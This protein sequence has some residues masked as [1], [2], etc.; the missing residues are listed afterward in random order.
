MQNGVQVIPVPGMAGVVDEQTDH[1]LLEDLR[2]G[3]RDAATSLYERYA[4]RLRQLIRSKCSAAL[5]RRLDAD[6]I[7]QS[8]FHAFF[9]GA[10]GG[11]YQVPA[12][13]EIWPLL[14]VIALNKI[15]TQGS[16]HRAAKRDVR[17]TCGLDESKSLK[18]AV[19]DLEAPESV[20]FMQMVAD[21]ALERI[22]QNQREIIE[23]RMAGYEV[24]EIAQLVGRS[25][26]TVERILQSCRQ[27][28]SQILCEVESNGSFHGG[29][30]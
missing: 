14:L 13:E 20:P 5:A 28:L 3:N 24:E 11:C 4:D 22:P 15:R 27:L 10:K 1:Q 12:G 18:R 6:D 29:A 2:Q 17:L 19:L 16:F 26:R 8:V 23:L 7:L 25:K 30:A 21:E 9:K